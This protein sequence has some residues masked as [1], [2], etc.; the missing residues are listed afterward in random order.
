MNSRAHTPVEML[1]AV[2]SYIDDQGDIRHVDDNPDGFDAMGHIP[3]GQVENPEHA[4]I[5]EW[6]H[7]DR[8]VPE[9]EELGVYVGIGERAVN[10][11][12][13]VKAY[14]HASMLR[15]L[16]RTKNRKKIIEYGGEESIRRLITQYTERGRK[17]LSAGTGID[18]MLQKP[19]MILDG[20]G[21][22]YDKSQ[23]SDDLVQ[24]QFQLRDEMTAFGAQRHDDYTA[25][26][27]LEKTHE[28]ERNRDAFRKRMARQVINRVTTQHN[29][30]QS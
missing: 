5:D 15:G 9:S 24:Y 1:P 25:R 19:D 2:S 11:L 3:K 27:R 10:M 4:V 8:E 12:E 13:A 18:A 30:T 26:Q 22:P 28:I 6:Y 7:P 29:N 17:A 16:L 14:N 21:M 23:A 20:Y